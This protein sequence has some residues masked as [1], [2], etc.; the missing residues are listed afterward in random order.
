MNFN[1]TQEFCSFVNY[2][3]MKREI[4]LQRVRK[5]LQQHLNFKGK[6]FAR[7]TEGDREE[8]SSGG[9][10]AG[11]GPRCPGLAGDVPWAQGLCHK[12]HPPPTALGCTTGPS[13]LS[14]IPSSCISAPLPRDR[15]TR[16]QS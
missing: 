3:Q 5:G 7:K 8:M 16:D 14:P 6:L 9:E 12:P 13:L 4:F 15:D 10:G 1:F 2:F 11:E